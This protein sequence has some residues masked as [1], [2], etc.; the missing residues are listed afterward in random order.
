M[1]PR[2]PRGASPPP[3]PSQQEAQNVWGLKVSAKPALLLPP[4]QLSQPLNLNGHPPALI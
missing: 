3:P 2:G 4:P 1:Q